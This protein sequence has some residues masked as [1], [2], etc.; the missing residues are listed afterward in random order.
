MKYDGDLSFV[1]VALKISKYLKCVRTSTGPKDTQ[2]PYQFVILTSTAFYLPDI[3][4]IN[5]KITN[6]Y[7][8]TIIL[9]VKSMVARED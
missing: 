6:K 7:E 8:N 5:S 3:V 2:V 9:C 1:S 4:V